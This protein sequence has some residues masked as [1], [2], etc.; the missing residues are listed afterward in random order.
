LVWACAVAVAPIN[1]AAV[2]AVASSDFNMTHT[3]EFTIY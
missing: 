3:P 1:M 2:A